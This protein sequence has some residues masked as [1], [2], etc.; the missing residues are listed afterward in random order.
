VATQKL[1]MVF[2]AWFDS[3]PG[4]HPLPVIARGVECKTARREF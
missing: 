1:C 4:L 2:Q 3:R